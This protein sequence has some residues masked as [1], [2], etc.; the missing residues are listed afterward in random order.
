MSEPR[1]TQGQWKAISELN[2]HLSVSAGAGAGKTWVLTQRYAAMLAGRPM[3]LPPL[4][5]EAEAATRP[6]NEPSRPHQIVAITFTKE[7]AGEMKERIRERLGQWKREA[8]ASEKRQIALL[9]EEVERATIT[10][11]HGFCSQLLREYP[12]EAGIDPQFRVM[13]ESEARFWL[14]ESIREALDEGLAADDGAVIRLITEYGY[15]PLVGELLRFYPSLREQTEDFLSI[16]DLTLAK[17][18]GLGEQLAEKV[19]R[20]ESLL[21]N[22]VSIAPTLDASKASAKR[23][24]RLQAEWEF[25]EG[26]IREWRKSGYGFEAGILEL[27]N[28]LLSGWGVLVK[29]LKQDVPPMKQLVESLFSLLVP[30]EMKVAVSDLCS[31]LERVHTIYTARKAKERALD[32]TDLQNRAVTLLQHPA[33][34]KWQG[35]R[36]RFLMVDEFQDTNPVQKRLIDALS[37][38][39][40][41]LRLFVVGDAKQSIYRFR[42]ADLEVFLRTQ[43]QVRAAEGEHVSLAHNF[44]TQEPIIAFV[45]RLFARLMPPLED[46]PRYATQYEPMEA[47]RQPAHGLPMVEILHLPESDNATSEKLKE[48][49]AIAARIQEMVV[50]KES[51]VAARDGLRPVQ[52]R[53]ITLLFSAMTHVSIYEHA[54]QTQ[55]IPY[56]IVGSRHFFSRQ[57]VHDL[58]LLM[59]G[60]VDERDVIAR[61]GTLRSPLFGVSD[62]AIYWL[63]RDGVLA[64]D[65]EGTA[66][67]AK[68]ADD[69]QVKLIRAARLLSTWRREKSFKSAGDLLATVM[70][71]TGYEQTLLLTFGGGQKV[72]NVRKL[73]QYAYE[74]PGERA[75]VL[76]F[77]QYING[78]IESDVKEED[79]QVESEQSDVVKIMTV[80][81]SK[82]LEFPVV[83]L[84]DMGRTCNTGLDGRFQYD[85]EC[86]LVM[87]FSEHEEWNDLAF[88]SILK[89]QNK[90]KSL[91]EER[92]KLYVAMTRARD[93]LLLVG[94]R[95]QPKSKG[96]SM[97]RDSSRW[98]DWLVAAMADGEL[99]Q[100]PA[101]IA[102]EWT[103][104]KWN[105]LAEQSGDVEV[106]VK[107]VVAT[108][109]DL[110][111]SQ[112]AATS[113]RTPWMTWNEMTTTQP[114][115]VDTAQRLAN[116]A[117]AFP[118]LAP[119]KPRPDET[120]GIQLSV[121]ALLTYHSCPR[122]YFYKYEW[123]LPER[124]R[125][126]A[127]TEADVPED[128]IAWMDEPSEESMTSFD[129]TTARDAQ[130]LDPKERGTL[131]HRVLEW[132]D[133]PA[134]A[135][136]LIR[137]ALAER[138]IVGAQAEAWTSVLKRDVD[139]YVSSGLFQTVQS[140]PERKSELKFRLT[141]GPHDV[142]G[143]L[144]KVIRQADGQ[145]VVIDFKTNR[146]FQNQLKATTRH[147]TPQLQLYTLVVNRLLGWPV[148]K[149]VLY[150]TALNQESL[151]PVTEADLTA[152]EHEIAAT[153]QHIATHDEEEDFEQTQ[154]E[155]ACKNCGYLLLCKGITS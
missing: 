65:F 91:E 47:T 74:Q 140:A 5:L 68:I 88:A 46:G 86:G 27:F 78:M 107:E 12:L 98:F 115:T 147:Y 56:Y 82:G 39:N 61:I 153:C 142:T 1:S 108:E 85:G 45:N 40:Q 97:S 131:V 43:D 132:I 11:I 18:A 62:E 59:Q 33:V 134:E 79:A 149:A 26:Q 41:Q 31:L 151:V 126:M 35:E 6:A 111:M 150:F 73:L 28:G 54:L 8:D 103:E 139:A 13:E 94:T 125:E 49:G 67:W 23:A 77:L 16:A 10:T 89:E 25:I 128:S 2:K 118:L 22:I 117:L 15:E 135:D 95:D 42:G 69:D 48:A 146:I 29:D 32:F 152:T 136:E 14:D 133:D 30:A 24:L 119:L 99:A 137:R 138:K 81:K 38:D 7:A 70:E 102:A 129:R 148:E 50:E 84:P 17:L 4:E 154:D 53:D 55:G 93:Y 60:L 37:E 57:E 9:K 120:R 83:I 20:L 96:S 44:R 80:H 123:K 72:G 36:L 109:R 100:M 143:I 75:S 112:A 58:V 51:L 76:S 145:A 130:E 110:A 3:V 19:E 92:R 124:T 106:A 87:G 113:T 34:R 21:L 71:Q 121:S 52:Y 141:F 104:V 114:D 64:T 90:A 101:A 66:N 122:Q 63:G 144:D 127:R 155:H 116:R 105:S